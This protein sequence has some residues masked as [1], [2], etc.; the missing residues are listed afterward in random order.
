ME[1]WQI[2]SLSRDIFLEG[3]NAG[4]AKRISMPGL[5][6]LEE[7]MEIFW[8][9][10]ETLAAKGVEIDNEYLIEALNGNP[11]NIEIGILAFFQYEARHR[12]RS[13]WHPTNFLARAIKNGWK[14]N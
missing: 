7:E 5:E 1:V 9:H 11:N 13:Q 2:A 10:A 12:F 3:T 4:E 6:L 14:P 8:L